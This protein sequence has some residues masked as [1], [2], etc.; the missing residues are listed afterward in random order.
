MGSPGLPWQY[1]LGGALSELLGA[2][3]QSLSL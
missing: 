2:V 1:Q 3:Q